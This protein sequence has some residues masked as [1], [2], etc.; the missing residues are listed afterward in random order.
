MTDP[1]YFLYS[2]PGADFE[3]AD[4]TDGL[5]GADEWLAAEPPETSLPPDDEF[6]ALAALL[7]GVTT[8]SSDE[9]PI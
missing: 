4:E 9:E 5:A 1:T 8:S 7:G 6:E 3:G 2:P